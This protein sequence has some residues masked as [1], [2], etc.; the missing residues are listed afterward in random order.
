MSS[1]ETTLNT[2]NQRNTNYSTK[3]LTVWNPRTITVDVTNSTYDDITYAEGTVFGRIAATNKGK[4]LASNAS[5][6]SQFPLGVLIC[7][8]IIE[9]GET[10]TLTLVVSGDIPEDMIVLTNEGDTLA[11]VVSSKTIRDRIGSDT[12][13]IKLV[14]GTELTAYDNS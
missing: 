1:N 3:K 9:A 5:D 11:T 8:T 2:N 7:E 12:V 14:G 13:G 10:I 6:G 4:A